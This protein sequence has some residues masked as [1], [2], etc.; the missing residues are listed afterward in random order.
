MKRVFTA[1][2]MGC[3]FCLLCMT[4]SAQLINELDINP[5]STDQ[6]CE[7]VE[8]RGTPGAIIE[9]VHFVAFEGDAIPSGTADFVVTFG[10]PGP[11]FG[12]NGLIVITGTVACGT[13]TYPPGTTRLQTALL[14]T[15][16]GLENGTI[17]FLLIS[18]ATAITPATD[19]DTDND[20]TLELLPADAV[21][22]DAVAWT[23][24][25]AGDLTYGGVV[26]N[27]TGGTI[28]AATRFSDNTNPRSGAAWYGG[29]MTGANDA[30]T[31]SS[32][33]RTLNFPTA[34]A[35]TPGAPNIGTTP[36]DAVVDFN[37]DGMTDYAVT[38]P[39]AGVGSQLTWFTQLRGGSPRTPQQWGI[40]GDQV[41][42]GDFDGDGRDDVGVF[43]SS[44][45]TFYI[46]N[47]STQ[48]I[49][50]DPFGQVGD[51]ARVV[52]DYD[53]DGR[54]DV[55][56]Y[57]SGPQSAWFYKTSEDGNIKSILWGEAGDFPSPGDY[58]GDGKFD[59]VVQR[60]EGSVG[61]FYLR[62][63]N[64]NF[65]IRT[66]GLSTDQIVPGD[67]DGD[68]KTDLCVVRDNAGGFLDWEFLSS[69]TGSAVIDEWGVA[70]TDFIAQGDYDG[71]GK[72]D[73]SVW[74][75]GSPGRFYTMTVGDRRIFSKL[76]GETGDTPVARYNT[77]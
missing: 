57:R 65:D 30:T 47:S 23:D 24:G 20:G 36:N 73:Y 48:T 66:L 1:A 62:F 19:Y 17:S 56:V 69:V 34:G 27:A 6:P 50:I 54:D 35:L 16:N 25:G 18:S 72:T 59:F 70:A 53:G 22:L 28:G 39:A 14:D 42:S 15:S 60:A 29:A 58:D 9:N 26:L 43:R 4:V 2:A 41:I 75:P 74:R 76:W 71:D 45:A 11:A 5:G 3:L 32:T 44:N 7:Y 63:A 55:A 51:D 49:R 10:S 46:I 38:R 77:Y 61:R 33:I 37:G 40:S 13:R 67:Y 12:S 52:G 64:G 8:L 21:I 68:G 31:Y